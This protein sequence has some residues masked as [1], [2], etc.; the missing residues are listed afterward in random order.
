L[1][2][3]AQAMDIP[4]PADL[5]LQDLAAAAAVATFTTVR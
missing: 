3:L 2:G 1:V 4:A 5:K